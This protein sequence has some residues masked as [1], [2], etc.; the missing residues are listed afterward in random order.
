MSAVEGR[1]VP[2]GAVA[3]Q[4]SG[5]TVLI[6]EADLELV[7]GY[8]WRA[9]KSKSGKVYAY[10]VVG[11][12]TVGLH[13]L[14]LGTDSG[15]DT[16]HRDGNPLNNRRSNLRPATHSQNMANKAAHRNNR[17][18]LKG[19]Y[20][21]PMGKGGGRPWRAAIQAKKRRHFL[22]TFTTAEQAARA[23]DEAAREHH[24][25]FAHLNFPNEVSS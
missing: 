8:R 9:M 12:K 10:T 22:G 3:I 1:P 18:G 20:R 7:G 16:D 15:L 23:Y 21:A 5:Y 17:S 6:D 24:G 13:R 4:V 14:I 2:E 11:G 25:E 19:V